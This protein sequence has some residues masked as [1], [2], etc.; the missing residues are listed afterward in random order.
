[1]KYKNIVPAGSYIQKKLENKTIRILL[2]E[3][4]TKTEIA[5]IVSTAREKAGLS[6]REFARLAG[7]TQAVVAR[8]ELGTDRRVPS[9]MLICRLLKAANA[10]LEIKCVFDMVA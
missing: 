7:T 1:M 3:E 5:R 4:K 9:L 10:H 2:D 8:L 6:Q